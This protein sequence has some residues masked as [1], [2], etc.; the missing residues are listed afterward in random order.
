MYYLLILSISV[1]NS[2]IYNVSPVCNANSFVILIVG[3]TNETKA[4][5]LR[6]ILA[7]MEFTYVICSY[8]EKGIPFRHHLYVPESVPN[9][10]VDYPY[11]EREDSAHILKVCTIMDRMHIW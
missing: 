10:Q 1:V 11:H 2:L 8:H 3:A 7:Q 6:S 4:E 5:K 9:D